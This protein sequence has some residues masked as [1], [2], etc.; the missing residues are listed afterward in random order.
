MG[1]RNR[2]VPGDPTP[3]HNLGVC[4]QTRWVRNYRRNKRG[5]WVKL[6]CCRLKHRKGD[7][8]H[9][10]PRLQEIDL[11]AGQQ[12]VWREWT[13]YTDQWVQEEEE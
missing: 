5:V 10:D 8:R 13:A 11:G 1:S 7:G 3:S 2:R 6:T 4:R 9:F 12:D